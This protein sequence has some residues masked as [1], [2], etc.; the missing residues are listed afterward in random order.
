[1][2]LRTRSTKSSPAPLR[3][4]MREKEEGADRSEVRRGEYQLTEFRLNHQVVEVWED[5]RPLAVI[6]PMDGGA[7][8]ISKNIGSRDQVLV[9]MSYPPSVHIDILKRGFS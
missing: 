7:K 3:R 8:L 1:M 5:G 2:L 4:R 9:D 6:Y